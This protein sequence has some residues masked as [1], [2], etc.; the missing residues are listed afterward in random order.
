MQKEQKNF[1]ELAKRYEIGIYIA[2]I[3]FFILVGAMGIGYF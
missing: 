1:F 2:L 3:I